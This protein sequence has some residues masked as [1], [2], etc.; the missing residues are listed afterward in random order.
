M[1][2]LY[3]RLCG[4]QIAVQTLEGRFARLPKDMTL[5]VA[6]A[7]S[8]E[9]LGLDLTV[10]EFGG[11][12][13][14]LSGDT[15]Q[16]VKPFPEC[17]RK[18]FK[19]LFG[20]I[21]E[22]RW[23]GMFQ[24]VVYII[25]RCLHS[26][27]CQRPPLRDFRRLALFGIIQS[28]VA[29]AKAEREGITLMS[30]FLDCDSFINATFLSPFSSDLVAL[31][32]QTGMHHDGDGDGEGEGFMKESM[33]LA[34]ESSLKAFDSRVIESAIERVTGYI[35]C[36][37]ELLSIA[38]KQANN[39]H[40]A[41]TCDDD[42]LGLF[43]A[44]AGADHRWVT[45]HA[46]EIL[47]GVLSKGILPGVAVFVL[48]YLSTDASQ[49]SGD[50]RFKG[51]EDR[52]RDTKGLSVG[53][54][55]IVRMS[56][57]LQ[58][59][60]ICLCS[61]S[62]DL[63]LPA[64]LSE[65]N[66]YE[67]D[68]EELVIFRRILDMRRMAEA[69][70]RSCLTTCL[71]LVTGEEA[72]LAPWGPSCSTLLQA[73]P[74][75]FPP[76]SPLM[77]S[78]VLGTVLGCVWKA[79]T[80]KLFEPLL[81]ALV[82]E[83]GKGSQRMALGGDCLM[84]AEKVVESLTMQASASASG[85]LKV[86]VELEGE[87]ATEV[88]ATRGSAYFSSFFKVFRAL[89][90]EESSVGK[91]RERSQAGVVAAVALLL[92]QVSLRNLSE[93]G[94]KVTERRPAAPV[95]AVQESASWQRMQLLLDTR[96][97]TRLSLYFKTKELSMQV[98]LLKACQRAL[99]GCLLAAPE[100][101]LFEPYLSVGIDFSSECWVR[102]I[103]DI[104]RLKIEYSEVTMNAIECLRLMACRCEWM[105][106]WGAFDVL[107]ILCFVRQT[108]GKKM[109]LM[110]SEASECLRL[111][112]V[113]R[114]E[115]TRAMAD[116][117]IP[118]AE[119]IPGLTGPG[120][121]GPL[122]AEASDMVFGS[123]LGEQASFTTHL[124]EWVH[125]SFPSEIP[126]GPFVPGFKIPWGQLFDLVCEVS[127]WI[128]KTCLTLQINDSDVAARKGKAM[129]SV[130]VACKQITAV[131]RVLL[132][133]LKSAHTGAIA[134]TMN[135][136]WTSPTHDASDRAGSSASGGGGGLLGCFDQLVT[137]STQLDTFLSLKLQCQIVRTLCRL[138]QYGTQDLLYALLDCGV[139]RSIARFYE[140][141]VDAVLHVTKMNLLADYNREYKNMFTSVA[142]SWH[143]LLCLQD[144]KVIEEV[145]ECRILQR[146]VE[147]WLPCNHTLS[148]SGV[149]DVQYNPLAV[150]SMALSM[151]RNAIANA[152]S[153]HSINTEGRHDQDNLG[154]DECVIAEITRWMNTC[155]TV[156]REVRAVQ[157][158]K[159][160]PGGTK[161][162]LVSAVNERKTAADVLTVITHA[163]IHRLD[164]DMM[165]MTDT[166]SIPTLSS[167][168]YLV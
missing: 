22:I 7:F 135:C 49:L 73:H 21:P 119:D 25:S 13:R 158:P 164:E 141:V 130:D 133:A 43:L 55:L 15:A 144:K 95:P 156:S 145:V 88:M 123:T 67:T 115:G 90:A 48:R 125:F 110:R 64:L 153:T 149:V 56:K 52:D 105:R 45:T 32:A 113:H 80:Y 116:L 60:N 20:M 121:L 93:D 28:D 89:C 94:N 117:R 154:L 65:H 107:S 131:E 57:F 36:I 34:E 75:L 1:Q 62:R 161:S 76:A 157:A 66:S 63:V 129:L 23:Y 26:D 126:L 92:P 83:D 142:V 100:V 151:L 114:P 112:T 143:A 12:V 44:S 69:L 108:R 68:T 18:M 59:V 162:A 148:L 97:A 27:P 29:V 139:I 74:L 138:M 10:Q 91:A 155:N 87:G 78:P 58:Y 46:V 53:S 79:H 101:G 35:G 8:I 77:G 150:R 160:S 96:I 111:S 6:H 128:Q 11:L 166:R 137:S 14:S 168:I 31:L 163:G 85:V 159:P 136:I 16:K 103:S 118:N 39:R 17:A 147:N 124:L 120:P 98:A 104:L 134:A 102:G 40:T 72:P 2:V 50:V 33:D 5:S 9:S 54:R 37:E 3:A 167:I 47:Y 106:H 152:H 165:V 140:Y 86:Q 42:G 99:S 70:Y 132:Y 4:G 61:L 24:Q 109:A 122:L 19:A 38:V 71:M 51:S 82:G 127:S 84:Q 41:V 81:L 146:M 30:P